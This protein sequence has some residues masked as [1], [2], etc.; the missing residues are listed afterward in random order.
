MFKVIL[1]GF[2]SLSVCI[3]SF[4]QTKIMHLTVDEKIPDLKLSNFFNEP[5]KKLKLSELNVK[6]VILDFWNTSCSSCILAM[7]KMDSLQKKYRDKIQIILV[8][9][10]T[11][12][13]VNKLFSKIK[14]KKPDL[15]IIISDSILYK[16]FP[17]TSVPHHVWIDNKRKVKYISD[18][19]NT[20]SDNIQS[21]LNGKDIKLH[22]KNESEEFDEHQSFLAEGNGRLMKN[23][24]SYS[25]IVNMIDEYGG[26]AFFLNQDTINRLV[27]LKIINSSILSLYKVAFGESIIRAGKFEYDSRIILEVKNPSN[28]LYP[29]D[30]ANRDAWMSKNVYG[31]ESRITYDRKS[32]LYT[33]MQQDL[34]RYFPYE[35]RVEKRMR[36]CYVLIRTTD[37]DKLKT[38]SEN[39]KSLDD[40]NTLKNVPFSTLVNRLYAI[41]YSFP[42][43]FVNEVKY[44]GNIDFE[45]SKNANE[46]LDASNLRKQLLRY[47]LCIIEQEREIEVLV[48]KDK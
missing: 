12:N 11:Q 24:Q 13:E 10:N 48:I 18:G 9:R 28:L 44:E 35:G 3:A 38:T 37:E 1:Q 43:P 27:G 16:Y 5:E 41:S 17:H 47:G 39:S 32:E 8:T 33:I 26:N 15:P 45:I 29:A 23:L 31:Y 20:T 22:Y 46:I 2:L 7:P 6:L 42:F 4:S 21:V 19:Y 25:A 40:G 14:I 30:E 34:N 36:K